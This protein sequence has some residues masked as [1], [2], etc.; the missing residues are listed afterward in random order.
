MSFWDDVGD[1][2]SGAADAVADAV[3]DVVNAV[4]EVVTDVVE[5]VGDAVS[6]AAGAVGDALGEIPVVGGVLSAVFHWIG[7]VVSG[8]TDLVGS[9]IKGVFGIIG[10]VIAGGI[11]VV[12]GGI[13]GLL[14]WD[15]RVFVKGL[16]DIVSGIGGA[17]VVIVGKAI[18]LVQSIIPLQW[19]KRPLTRSERA[20]LRR[21]FRESVALYNI[22]I[23][24][25]FAGIYSIN[26][27]PFTLG[28]TVYMKN[29]NPAK[30]PDLLVHECTHVWQ[31]QN[32][33]TRYAAD[34]IGAQWF[35]NNAYDWESELSLGHN[36]WQ[37]FNA[38]AECKFLEDV[39]DDGRVIGMPATGNGEFYDNDPVG[40]NVEFVFNSID[41]TVLAKDSVAYVRA[42]FAWRL[43][44]LL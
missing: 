32:L 6:D 29:F 17:V 10:G 12:F 8:V 33:G 19:G 20:I 42:A 41:R 25:G 34:A 38:E 2:I 40:S 13:G 30:N 37:D 15:G 22:R 27:Y 35:A 5:T 39:F 3:E 18:G 28:N 43:S 23:I 31:Y 26:D 9:A 44:A 11:R 1:A 36:R 14:S 24:E 21:V 7:D 16:V 4:E